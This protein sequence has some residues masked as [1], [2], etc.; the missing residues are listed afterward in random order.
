MSNYI[1]L[2]TSTCD[3]YSLTTDLAR[4][5]AL[6]RTEYRLARRQDDPLTAIV[7]ATLSTA[8]TWKWLR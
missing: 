8:E 6:W 2:V 3:G 1:P 5:A 7:T 4:L